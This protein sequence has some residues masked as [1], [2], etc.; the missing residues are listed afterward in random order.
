MERNLKAILQSYYQQLKK[1]QYIVP[2]DAVDRM[3]KK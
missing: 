1:Q 2:H 3:S